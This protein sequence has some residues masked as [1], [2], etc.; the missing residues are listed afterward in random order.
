MREEFAVKP[1]EG[2]PWDV[3][4]IGSGPASLT[5]AIYTTRGAASTLILAGEKWGGQLMLTTQVDNYPGFPDGIQGPI[6]MMAMRKQAVRFGAEFIEKDVEEVNFLSNPFELFVNR[7]KYLAKTVIIATG[8]KTRW[9]SVPGEERLLG[10]GV[11]SCAPCDAPLFKNKRVA[12][13]GGGDSA[14]EEALVLVKYA[15]S[16][17]IIHRRNEFRASAA[18]QSRVKN[19]PKMKIIWDSAVKEII[20]EQKLEKLKIWNLK[21][22]Q[23]SEIEVDGVF[24]AIGHSPST[25]IFK[26]KVDLDEKGYVKVFD[27]TKTSVE[28][29]FV[30]GDVHDVNYRQAVT[31]AGFGCMAAF[32]VIRYLDKNTTVVKNS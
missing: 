13:I 32:E 7:K 11:S 1:K 8:A 2:E 17:T 25:E 9:L 19:N 30:A 20:G 22:S 26:D 28:G 29:V 27:H 15:S 6:L 14:M 18:M 10:R 24:V 4:I 5:A 3:V 21:T 31:A 12:V 16:V 23:E